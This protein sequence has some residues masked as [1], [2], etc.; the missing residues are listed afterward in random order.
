MFNNLFSSLNS[1]AKEYIGISLNTNGLLEVIQTSKTNTEI[2]K[3]TNRFVNYNAITREVESYEALKA[4][5]EGALTELNINPKNCMATVSLPNVHFGITELPEILSDD[6]ISNAL[7][8]QVEE[9]YIFKRQEPVI[10]WYRLST[11]DSSSQ[12]AYSALQDSALKEIKA[13]CADL[14]ITLVSVQN[15]LSELLT[16]L[17]FSELTAK[18]IP[19]D[20]SAWNLLL[21]SSTSYSIFNFIGDKLNSYYEEP[22]AVKSFTDEEVYTAVGSMASS[23]LQNYPATNLLIISETDEVSA[24]VISTKLSTSSIPF[25]IEQNKYQQQPSLKV[26]LDVLPGYIPQIT[27]AAVGASVDHF[28]NRAVKFNYLA[29]S[30]SNLE[31]GDLITIG[32]RTFELTKDNVTKFTI[33]VVIAIAVILGGLGFA[34]HT[35]INGLNEKLNQLTQE[36]TQLKNELKTYTEQPT[37]VNIASTIDSIVKSNRK[38]MLYYDALSYGIPDK[39]WIESFYAGSGDAIGINGVSLDSN[40]IAEFLK[41]IREVAG[42]SE[43]SVTKLTITG[44]DDIINRSEPELYSF[45]LANQAYKNSS[46]AQ[47]TDSTTGTTGAAA[48]N[49]PAQPQPQ[50]QQPNYG[51]N[52]IPPVNNPA[53]MPPVIPAE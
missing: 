11:S 16:G 40:D 21:I 26:S 49:T 52:N 5:I 46:N 42:E 53:A 9:S 1:G 31:A 39:L 14:G 22:L 28:E 36:E 6:E 50:A 32:D 44:S 29:N 24:E 30:N 47:N 43:I 8:S 45:E 7:I 13:L 18:I 10:S 34:M 38:K 12:I 23:A 41:G 37:T 25:Y 2:Q 3:Y 33:A 17:S 48:Q 35:L 20:K 27:I 15:S 19:A 4:E 51:G